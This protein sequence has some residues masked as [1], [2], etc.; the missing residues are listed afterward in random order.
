MVKGVTI[1]WQRYQWKK[2]LLLM[3]AGLLTGCTLSPSIPVL[4]AAFPAWLF[5]SL[6]GAL[7]LIPTH[8]LLARQ[9]WLRPFSPLVISYL[10]LMFIYAVIVWLLFF[11]G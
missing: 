2:P 11:M 8:L 6:V 9:E 4:G 3:L 1:V 10:A 5:C 7:L